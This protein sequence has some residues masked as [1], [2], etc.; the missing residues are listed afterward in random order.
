MPS[1]QPPA[2]AFARVAAL[3]RLVDETYGPVI[4][5]ARTEADALLADIEQAHAML[6]GMVDML[7]TQHGRLVASEERVG[8][9][10]ATAIHE[11]RIALVAMLR[12]YREEVCEEAAN[13]VERGAHRGASPTP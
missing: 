11:E 13:V 6:R 12:T 2:S 5:V 4:P 1:F 9:L 7:L 10:V 8:S 3:R